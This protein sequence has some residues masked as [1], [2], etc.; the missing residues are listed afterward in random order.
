MS[1]LQPEK[2]ELRS[3]QTQKHNHALALPPADLSMSQDKEWCVVKIDG[4]WE[5]VRLHDYDRLYAV[6]GL[7]E[8]LIYDTLKCDSPTVIR[9][10]LEQQ[11]DD[12][13]VDASKL[14]VLDVG[15]GNGMVGEQ[16][17][18]MGADTIV[19]VDIIDEAAEA[20]ER[21]RP[22][23]YENYHIVDL[24]DLS[25]DDKR[26]LAGYRF[27]AMTC[28]AALGFGDIPV[29]AFVT[30]F[31]LVH[32][33]GWIAFN[34]KEKFLDDS[35]DSGFSKLVRRMLDDGTLVAKKQ[36]RYRHRIGTDRQPLNYVAIVGKKMRDVTA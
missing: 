7:Y 16:F 10:L 3:K 32:D 6:P 20:T 27:N 2:P 36:K 23:V 24:T 25:D 5:Q 1:I 15:A 22:G 19:G 4:K 21:D 30:A 33:G 8:Y 18:D 9:Q 26:E 14:R 35:D 28:V 13:N 31:N 29:E 11:L 17:A 34:I 12:E